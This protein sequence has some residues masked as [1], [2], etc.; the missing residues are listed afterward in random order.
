MIT[1]LNKNRVTVRDKCPQIDVQ[2]K[3]HTFKK[4]KFRTDGQTDGRTDRQTNK[5]TDGPSDYI[6]P[7]ILFGGIKMS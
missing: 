6:M 2:F 7:Q 5:R 1:C 3:W 4:K